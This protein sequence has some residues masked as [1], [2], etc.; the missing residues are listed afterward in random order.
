MPIEQKAGADV[1]CRCVYT[2]SLQWDNISGN[3]YNGTGG[4]IRIA[5][6]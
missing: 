1:V 4:R 2:C 5:L 6:L 3:D